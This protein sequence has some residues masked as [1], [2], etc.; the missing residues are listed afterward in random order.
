MTGHRRRV[1]AVRRCVVGVAVAVCLATGA[2][3]CGDDG[4]T[5]P[6]T[7]DEASFCRLAESI[8]PVAEA[9][10]ASLVALEELAPDEVRAQVGVLRDLAERVADLGDGDPEGLALEFEVRFSDEFVAA[11]RDVE[12]Y[13]REECA[14][15]ATTTTADPDDESGGSTASTSTT[16]RSTTTAGGAGADDDT[17]STTKDKGTDG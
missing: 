8:E 14:P 5:D 11:R 10:A 16:S 17:T 2:A 13:Q 3:A 12:A 15:E 7:G 1:G 4:G 6:D 9:D